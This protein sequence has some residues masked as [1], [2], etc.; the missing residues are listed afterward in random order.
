MDTIYSDEEFNERKEL[1]THNKPY[2][3]ES[4]YYREVFEKLYSNCSHIIPYFWKQPF[5]KDDDPSA[6]CV[7]KNKD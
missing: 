6:W 4:L 7:E 1:Y 3:K 5:L 2:D